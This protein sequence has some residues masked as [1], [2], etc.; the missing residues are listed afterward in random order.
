[1]NKN[2]SKKVW[3]QCLT[4]L[5]SYCGCYSNTILS[6]CCQHRRSHRTGCTGPDPTNFWDSN[7]GPS[8]NFVSKYWFT[9]Q[10][11]LPS[12]QPRRR[13]WLPRLLHL[14]SP[15]CSSFCSA[16]HLNHPH[17]ATLFVSTYVIARVLSRFIVTS[18]SILKFYVTW[19][20]K[21]FLKIVV[22]HTLILTDLY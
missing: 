12:F 4:Y 7:M 18:R 20:N 8:Q 11:T 1:M 5:F 22:C 2:K 16:P 19:W 14:S 21:Q 9:T 6:N 13:P 17:I 10:W 3:L 15:S